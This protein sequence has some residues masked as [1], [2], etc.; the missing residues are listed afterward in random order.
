MI[1]TYGQ[2]A[3]LF[4]HINRK[5]CVAQTLRVEKGYILFHSSVTRLVSCTFIRK[6]KLGFSETVGFIIDSV[7]VVMNASNILNGVKC[8]YY[9]R[10]NRSDSIVTLQK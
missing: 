5:V 6:Y 10:L 7:N 3:F 4:R 1:F 2:N 8:N 9:L